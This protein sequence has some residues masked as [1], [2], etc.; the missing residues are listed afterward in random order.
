[1]RKI[2][3]VLRLHKLGLGRRE[4]A[5]CCSI[6]QSTGHDYLEKPTKTGTEPE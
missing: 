6:G 1:M 5:R 4:I 2:T 3:E